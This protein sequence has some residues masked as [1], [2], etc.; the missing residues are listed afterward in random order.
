VANPLIWL[1]IAIGGYDVSA[2]MLVE[3]TVTEGTL[4]H[5]GPV[6]VTYKVELLPPQ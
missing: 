4:K 3:G 2:P 5:N 6:T 1:R